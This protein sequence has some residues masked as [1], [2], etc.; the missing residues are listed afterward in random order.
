[1]SGL[2][3]LFLKNPL[4]IVSILGGGRD[5]CKVGTRS[6]VKPVFDFGSFPKAKSK[7]QHKISSKDLLK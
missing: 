7:K 2:R 5:V 6:Q 4:I 1:L 3:S